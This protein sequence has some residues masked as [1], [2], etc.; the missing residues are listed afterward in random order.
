MDNKVAKNLIKIILGILLILGIAW[1]I[2]C[3]CINLKSLS[4]AS[5]RDYIQGFGRF[6]AIVYVLA[7]TL[8]TVSLL[9]PI[10]FL[11]LSAGLAFGKVW[12][13]ILLLLGAS[14]GSSCT[15]FIARFF[16]RQ[17][18]EKL[19][20]GRFSGLDESLAKKGF[21][22]VLFFRLI[23]IVPYEA[24]NYIPGLSKIKFRSYFFASL[25]GF[26]PGVFVSAFFGGE[27]GGVRRFKDVL[28]FKFL[29]ALIAFIVMVCV[30][31]VYQYL[32]NKRKGKEAER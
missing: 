11:S 21:V 23:P 24:L 28:S 16:G 20:R 32:K 3:A 18:V 7:Y 30:P 2:K 9:P 1:M 26:I 13:A 5:I 4:P 6:A 19:L 27:L 22:T 25:I 29:L 15:F 31:I 12:G 17:A 14:L 10:G 8:N